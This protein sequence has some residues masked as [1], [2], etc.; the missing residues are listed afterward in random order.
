[1]CGHVLEDPEGFVV[2]HRR[3]A[4]SCLS[5]ALKHVDTCVQATTR[6]DT[7]GVCVCVCVRAD[8]QLS[9]PWPG[10]T[11]VKIKMAGSPHLK[12]PL[13]PGLHPWL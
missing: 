10:F 9:S 3:L 8:R 7:V 5:A 12:L 1:M 6:N 4:L 2:R 11:K 13:L